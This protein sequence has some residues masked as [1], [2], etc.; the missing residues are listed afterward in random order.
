MIVNVPLFYY[1]T[2]QS[3]FVLA[4]GKH[5][6]VSYKFVFKIIK[7]FFCLQTAFCIVILSKNKLKS[8]HNLLWDT[9]YN[10]DTID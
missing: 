6:E 9:L 5:L 2:F 4:N 7:T 8:C 3:T 1:E 10:F